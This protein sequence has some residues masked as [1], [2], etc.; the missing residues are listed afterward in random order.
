[1]NA[2]IQSHPIGDQLAD[3]VANLAYLSQHYYTLAQIA[4]QSGVDEPRL[5]AMIERACLPPHSHEVSFNF[6]CSTVLWGESAFVSKQHFYP[7]ALIAWAKRAALLSASMPLDQVA[8]QVRDDFFVELQQALLHCVGARVAN[9]TCFG[10]DGA[11]DAAGLHAWQQQTWD[12]VMDGTYG[13]CLRE[14]SARNIVRKGAAVHHLSLALA[15]PPIDGSATTELDF[16]LREY[17][18]VASDFAPLERARSSRESV[19][20]A[21]KRRLQQENLRVA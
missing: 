1:M 9:P 3:S 16:F 19:F 18:D 7:N 12:Y 15:S 14:I 2:A 20:N 4:E 13:I 5:L 6:T 11:F 8:T 21:L 10:D 17:D